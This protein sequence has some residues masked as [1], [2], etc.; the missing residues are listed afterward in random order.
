MAKIKTWWDNINPGDKIVW[1]GIAGI[2]LLILLALSVPARAG[3]TPRHSIAETVHQMHEAGASCSAVMIA[4]ERALTAAHCLGMNAPVV[5]INGYDYPVLEG[6]AASPRDIAILIIP[7]APCPCARFADTT[8][9]E[10]DPAVVVGYPWA[11]L[12]VV[13]YGEIQGRIVLEEDG[14]EYLF[15]TALVAPGNSGGGVFDK[16]GDLI[17]IV[18]KGAQGHSLLAVEIVSITMSNPRSFRRQK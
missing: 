10:G 16:Y 4:P 17:G 18:S 6:Y 7:G 14:Q 5:T 8:A 2:V 13:T 3:H 1:A 9:E 11:M 15:V 12:R